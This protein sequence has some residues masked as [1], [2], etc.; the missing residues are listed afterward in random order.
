MYIRKVTQ[1]NQKTGKQYFTHRLAETYRTPDGKVRQRVL[2]TLGKS[3]DLSPDE[4][5]LLADR[6]EEIMTGQQSMI[7][8]KKEIEVFAQDIA[9]RVVKRF[10]DRKPTFTKRKAQPDQSAGSPIEQ[11]T[12]QAKQAKQ[13]EKDYH[14]VDLNS[15]EYQNVRQIGAEHVGLEIA[16]E[17]QLDRVLAE[18]KFNRK[19]INAAMGSIIGRLTFPGS[20]R[21]THKYLQH[22]S[23]LDELLETDFGKLSLNQLYQISDKLEKNKSVIEKQLFEREKNLFQFSEVITLYDLTNTYFEGQAKSVTKAAFGRS[24]EK[25]SDCPLVTLALVLDATGFPKKSEVFEGNISEAKTLEKMISSLEG[26]K[27]PIIVMDAGIATEQ[28]IEWLK[29]QG[30]QY[31][32]VSRQAKQ[33]IFDEEDENIKTIQHEK[34]Y[35]IKAKLEIDKETGE[36]NLYCYSEMK[37]EKEQSMGKQSSFRFEKELQ[38]LSEGL[39]KKGAVKQYQKI[40][41][42]IGRLKERYKRVAML[43]EINVIADETNK[44]AIGVQWKKQKDYKKSPGVYCLRSN[45]DSLDEQRLWDIYIM[46]TDLES[47][48]RCLKSELGLRPVYH[49][50]TVRVDSHLFISVMAYHL[51]HTIRLKLKEKG[52]HESW[53]VLRKELNTHCRIT[54][55]MKSSA[56]KTI[57]VRKSSHPTPRQAEIY[58]ALGISKIPG[59]TEKTIF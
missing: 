32:V 19:Q 8:A 54:S 42:R 38:R 57:H 5:K 34:H 46:L 48:F 47:A 13:T 23:A 36:R 59:K 25:R 18:L 17:L 12:K 28:N 50:K 27:K 15:I 10:S 7:P 53:G 45:I 52:I 16:K 24:K 37:F 1:K 6:A 40:I 35:E 31:I 39:K 21:S 26:E 20:E 56:G 58:Q 9:K 4:W 29:T 44:T 51:L 41:E 2:L 30:Y 33:F 49:R 55:T 22:N 14:E 11:Q 3:F 43:Y